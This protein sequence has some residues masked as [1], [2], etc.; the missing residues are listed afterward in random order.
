[1]TW[2]TASVNRSENGEDGALWPPVKGEAG[3]P[4]NPAIPGNVW[5]AAA[6]I[7]L[8]AVIMISPC[9]LS[10]V[11]AR[12]LTPSFVFLLAN[13]DLAISKAEVIML[14]SA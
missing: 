4:F 10:S 5:V 9:G 2:P 1:L 8:I 12:F 14:F 11:P 6:A 7:E 13:Y 3:A